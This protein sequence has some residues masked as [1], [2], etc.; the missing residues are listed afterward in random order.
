MARPMPLDH[1]KS[2]KKPVTKRVPIVLDSDIADA[3]EEAKAA[4]EEAKRLDS[5]RSTDDTRSALV[6]AEEKLEEAR[7]LAEE[8]TAEF[9]LRSIGRKPFELLVD[10]HPPTEKQKAEAK[11]AGSEI[12]WNADTFPPALVAACLVEP[13]MSADDVLEM[14][15]SP[16]WNQ[17]ELLSL[18]F[19]AMDAN[20]NRR[21]ID[22]GKGSGQTPV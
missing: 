14:W 15:D 6:V 18:F 8:N 17:A 16:D 10:E 1:L 22:L 3:Y 21:M 20:Q 12:N 5:V 9:V 2:R 19:G 7:A 13:Q 11:K 4:Y